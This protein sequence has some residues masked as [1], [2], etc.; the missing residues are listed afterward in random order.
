[1]LND[2][3]S[4]AEQPAHAGSAGYALHEH[5]NAEVWTWAGAVAIA[6]DLRRDLAL[7]PRASLLLSGGTTPAPVYDA[8]SRAPLEWNRVDVGFAD[9]R[10]L[11]PEDRDSNAWLIREHLLRDHAATA[12]FQPLT[13]DGRS[14]DEVVASLN[15]AAPAPASTVVLGM[16]GDGHTASLFPGM[17]GLEQALAAEHDYLSV[18]AGDLPG[19]R[20]WR[21]RISLSPAGLARV[22]SRFLLIQGD[23]KREVFE[24]ALADGDPRRWPVLLALRGET[25]LQVHWCP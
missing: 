24:R 20:G 21:W 14:I 23:A 5:A 3:H 2:V 11:P 7:H 6:A 13:G 9:E 22:H 19:A 17:P 8:L 1:M 25:P 18:D 4:Q 10:W 16:G 15:A 12:H